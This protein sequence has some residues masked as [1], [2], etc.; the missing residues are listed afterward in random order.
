MIQAAIEGQPSQ[1]QDSNIIAYCIYTIPP[2]ARLIAGRLHDVSQSYDRHELGSEYLPASTDQLTNEA[3]EDVLQPQ[4]TRVAGLTVVN[5][6]LG[7]N[8]RSS[9]A[10]ATNGVCG[11]VSPPSSVK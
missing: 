5:P 6:R 2:A 3:Y 7:A 9:S 8:G 10:L 4:K 11:G 1:H